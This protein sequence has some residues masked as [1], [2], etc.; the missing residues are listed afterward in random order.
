M[1]Y[2]V[3]SNSKRNKEEKILL[4]ESNKFKVLITRYKLCISKQIKNIFSFIIQN[5]IFD[6]TLKKIFPMSLNNSINFQKS[7]P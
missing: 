2:L 1:I 4:N 5:I 6:F 3:I 7:Y